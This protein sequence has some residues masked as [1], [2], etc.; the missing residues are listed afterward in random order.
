MVSIDPK[1]GKQGH[2]EIHH[3]FRLRDNDRL[4]LEA[5]KP[6]ALPAMVALN[7]TYGREPAITRHLLYLLVRKGITPALS[8]MPDGRNCKGNTSITARIDLF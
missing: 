4:A 2:R 3:L 1:L 8:G 5:S 6:M 7:R